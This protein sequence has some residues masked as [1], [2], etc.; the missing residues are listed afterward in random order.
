MSVRLP[1]HCPVCINVHFELPPEHSDWL[2]GWY[3][4]A[5]VWGA[6]PYYV[7]KSEQEQTFLYWHVDCQE[8]QFSD[9]LGSDDPVAYSAQNAPNPCTVTTA[10]NALLQPRGNWQLLKME[11]VGS[12]ESLSVKMDDDHAPDVHLDAIYSVRGIHDG[13]PY[14]GSPSGYAMPAA[15]QLFLYWS[16]PKE[17]WV[18][19][20]ELGPSEGHATNKDDAPMPWQITSPWK[21]HDGGKRWRK[22]V[23]SITDAQAKPTL[24]AAMDVESDSDGPC[25]KRQKTRV[26]P[27]HDRKL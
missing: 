8:W 27:R 2:N 3:A 24:N 19:A 14:Y 9:G 7:R 12:W 1:Q 18:I 17:K 26:Q 16:R 4:L 25:K 22:V 21:V 13:R 15:N 23:I 5:G 10:W 20:A 6:R 11:A